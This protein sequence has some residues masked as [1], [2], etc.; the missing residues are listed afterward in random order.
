MRDENAAC[1]YATIILHVLFKF[2][3]LQLNNPDESILTWINVTSDVF[4][5]HWCF[6]RLSRRFF[7]IRLAHVEVYPQQLSSYCSK[8]VKLVKLFFMIHLHESDLC[9]M[10]V[11]VSPSVSLCVTEIKKKKETQGRARLALGRLSDKFKCFVFAGGNPDRPLEQ[12]LSS[13]GCV[14]GLF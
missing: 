2:N 11:S 3:F 14:W 5:L 10:S 13:P 1:F 12:G 6:C 4:L 7:S 8:K 9:Y